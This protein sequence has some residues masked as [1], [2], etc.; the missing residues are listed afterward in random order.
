MYD[1]SIFDYDELEIVNGTNADSGEFPFIVRN[2][3][4]VYNFKHNIFAGLLATKQ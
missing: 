2:V 4:C 3:K 1:E